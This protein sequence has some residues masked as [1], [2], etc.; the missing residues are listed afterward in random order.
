MKILKTAP[1]LILLFI[2]TL[3]ASCTYEP[4]DGTVEPDPNSGGNG[5]SG[6]FKADFNGSTWTAK[7]TEAIISGNFIQIAAIN[8][9]GESFGIMLDGSTVGTYAANVNLVSYSPAGT[10][11]GY[12]AINDN[13]PDENT[14]SVIITSINTANKTISGTFQFKGYWSDVPN[15]KTPITFTNGVFKDIR[16]PYYYKYYWS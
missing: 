5:E 3:I 16:K 8:A 7:E 12:L 10:E 1:K 9:K 15:T 13:N 11:F 2:A 4:V 6:I 14:G